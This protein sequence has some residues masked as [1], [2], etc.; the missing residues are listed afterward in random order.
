MNNRFIIIVP[1]YNAVKYIEDCLESILSQD[2]DNYELVVMDDCSTDGTWEKIGQVC[3]R[4]G[5]SF[6]MCRNESRLECPL[7]NFIKG[8][9]LFSF[10]KKDIL[11]FVDGDDALAGDDV[12]PYLNSVYQDPEVWLTYGQF[13]P[14]SLKYPPFCKPIPD[15]RLY[16]KSK[17]WMASHLKTFRRGLFDKINDKD[18][19]GV[20]GNY[21]KRVADTAIIYPMIE[22]CGQKHMR[23][24]E[25][26]LYIYNDM[27]PASEMYTNAIEQ[28]RLAKEIRE[29]PCYEELTAL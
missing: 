20:D 10:D 21:Y 17:L 14:M 6:S 3:N 27:N 24:I 1:V 16:R 9:E 2:Y 13:M 11:C 18:L 22:M 23:F 25:K 29:K 26:I 5:A 15:T 8:V 7:A 4:H 28:E 12:L 19:R